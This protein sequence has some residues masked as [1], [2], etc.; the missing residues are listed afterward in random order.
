MSTTMPLVSIITTSYNY[1][2]YIGETIRSVLAQ[3]YSHWE[4]IISDDGSTDHS[5]EII[6]SFEDA[7]IT[8]I[9]AERNRGAALA[10]RSAL[11]RCR[12]AYL[13]SLDSDD[14]IAPSQLERQVQFLEQHPD[15]DIL[16]TY[17]EEIDS[18][19]ATIGEGHQ[20]R[21]FNQEIDL[22]DPSAWVE[23]NHLCH[24]SVLMRRS[25]HDRL[26]TIRDDLIYTPDYELWMRC[27]L[28]GLRF[29]VLPERLTRYRV[30]TQ[31]ISLHGT[32]NERGFL[33]R[34]YLFCTYLKPLL[35]ARARHEQIMQTLTTFWRTAG[36]YFP[37]LSSAVIAAHITSLEATPFAAF[38][39]WVAAIRSGALPLAAQ[40]I[41]NLLADREDMRRNVEALEQHLRY[42]EDMTSGLEVELQNWQL[43]AEQRALWIRQLEAARDFHHQ[44]AQN[45]Q[46]IAEMRQPPAGT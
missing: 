26:G 28:A 21:W 13:M 23:R 18:T 33:E 40:I 6:R 34:L 24:S 15:I 27:L 10:Y 14:A 29:A 3:S 12:G 4:M 44:Q 45:W 22:N 35:E 36:Q 1:G 25:V 39:G 2:H 31:N 46:R 38:Q 41:N 7:R 11:E 8:L 30:H 32:G 17:I 19:G 9:T 42:V 20:A 16:G 43:T 37:A 5:I